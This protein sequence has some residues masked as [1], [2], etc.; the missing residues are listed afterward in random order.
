MIIDDSRMILKISKDIIEKHLPNMSIRVMEKPKEAMAELLRESYDIIILDIVMPE[1]TGIEMLKMLKSQERF[2]YLKIIMFTSLNDPKALKECFALGAYDFI[3]KPLDE[4]EFI[5]RLKHALNEYEQAETIRTNYEK[6]EQMNDQLSVLNG[7]LKKAQAEL[8]Q[9]ERLASVGHL[10]AGMA[11]EVNNPLGFL[12]SNINTLFS[13]Q[14]SI[15]DL[16]KEVKGLSLADSSLEERQ[17]NIKA[18]EED[19][20]YEFI[21][22]DWD[23]LNK[24]IDYGLKRIQTI[25]D[26]LR[27]F[28][29][30]D[31]GT[32]ESQFM[33]RDVTENILTMIQGQVNDGIQIQKDY[34]SATALV[35]DK[36]EFGLSLLSV[37]DNAI[38]AI[39]EKGLRDDGLL[40]IAVYDEK[41]TVVCQVRDN[42]IG[43]T[44]SILKHA[45]DPF[46][47][48]KDVG[49][50]VGLGLTTAYSNIVN[51]MNG[52]MT[53]TSEHG[54]GTTVT[55]TLPKG[56][57]DNE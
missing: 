39:K 41:D 16:Y 40:S 14:K 29:V 31:V 42:G 53:I 46:Y 37:I 9:K 26:A 52:D 13:N 36:A 5:A 17:K 2:D 1:V 3:T 7:S 24:D 50:G 18:K 8:I 4:D 28:S 44:D 20:D 49:E 51:K 47:T 57:V 27:K 54:R 19:F 56:E 43:M 35:G 55:I 33:V 30:V 11:H 21:K 32:G 22:E 45:F 48:T 6:L 12:N 34:Q 15:F 10:A 23:D 38:S 25:V